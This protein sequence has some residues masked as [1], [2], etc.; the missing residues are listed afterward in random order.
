M[1]LERW[2][3]ASKF[4]W[5]MIPDVKNSILYVWSK[6]LTRLTDGVLEDGKIRCVQII[7]K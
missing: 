6:L 4:L 5:P 1:G 2:D 7:W 3:Q